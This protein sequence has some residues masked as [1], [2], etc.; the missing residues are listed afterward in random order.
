MNSDL[1]N[2]LR[3]RNIFKMNGRYDFSGQRVLASEKTEARKRER[4]RG[5]IIPFADHIRM[6]ARQTQ[7]R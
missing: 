6:K 7:S 1:F 4:N 2:Y 3:S 5:F